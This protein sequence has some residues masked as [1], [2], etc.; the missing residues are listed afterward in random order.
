MSTGTSID[1]SGDLNP[2]P[3]PATPPA[4]PTPLRP[5]PGDDQ[6]VDS[7]VIA[8]AGGTRLAEHGHPAFPPPEPKKLHLARKALIAIVI[9]AAV[10]A[11]LYYG[12]PLLKEALSTVSTDDAFVSGHI[13][14]VGPRVEDVVTEVLVDQND[15][16]EPGMPLIRMDRVP[17]ETIVAQDEAAVQQARSQLDLSR[18]QVRAQLSGAR[19]SW[20]RRKNLQEQLRR[21]V[22]S[23][24]AQAATLRARESSLKLAE[25]DQHRLEVLAKRGS[26]TQAELDIRNNT[27]DVAREQVKEAWAMI[28][29][30]RAALGLEPNTT[31]PLDVPKDLEEQQSTIQSAVS[32]IANSLAQIGIPFDLGKL[33]PEET[34]EQVLN[35]D[36]SENLDKAFNRIID[37]APAVLVSQAALTRSQRQLD[38]SKLRLSYTE[39]RSEIA[40]YVEQR[41]VHPGNRVQPG[42]TLISIRPARIW[43]DANFKETQIHYLRIGMP[44]DLKVDAYPKKVFKARVAGFSPATGAA[45]SLLP[46]ENATGNYV[47]VTQRLP[48]RL[49][50]TEP[51]PADTPLFV[52][53]SVVP[54]VRVQ[55]KPT[56]PRAGERLRAASTAPPDVGAGPAAIQGLPGAIGP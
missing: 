26:A 43:V 8:D 38:E 45:S 37:K 50:L 41:S 11:A 6:L 39:I 40:G 15:H 29:E 36:S 35:L 28:Q 31:D 3:I 24:R 32:D 9:I 34:F 19:G 12:I 49:E 56:G 17:F 21:Q 48:V 22:A 44:V 42:Q 20:F 25:V 1:T 51:N 46:P 14:Y 54:V 10:G 18:A 5:Q 16:V 53:L 30:T 55:E 52:G 2:W 47:K 13:T 4:A 33:T 23:L 7:Q 27:L